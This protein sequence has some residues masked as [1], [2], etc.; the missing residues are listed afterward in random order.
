ML[1]PQ[2]I[3]RCQAPASPARLTLSPE[4]R[5]LLAAGPPPSAPPGTWA[6]REG[7]RG[8]DLPCYPPR[9]V[10]SRPGSWTKRA[11]CGAACTCWSH[12]LQRRGRGAVSGGPWGSPEHQG[13]QGAPS[14]MGQAGL[15]AGRGSGRLQ[16]PPRVHP[17]PG[18][19]SPGSAYLGHSQP[20][21]PQAG[22][23]WGGRSS[24][25]LYKGHCF[26]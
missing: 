12:R 9:P 23:G 24:F 8:A 19:A 26:V 22:W 7:E 5:V 16:L 10:G 21:H 2:G 14:Q 6:Q 11:S 25:S 1:R 4:L 18:A 17:V 15:E 13:R 20:C 3:C